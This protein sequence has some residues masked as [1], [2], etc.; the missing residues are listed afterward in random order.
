MY[1]EFVDCDKVL[2][3]VQERFTKLCIKFFS[4]HITAKNSFNR[5]RESRWLKHPPSPT[6]TQTNELAVINSH[7]NNQHEVS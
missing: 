7:A 3:V 1:A 4:Q 6:H 2:Y 5:I